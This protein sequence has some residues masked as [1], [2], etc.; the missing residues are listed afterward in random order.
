[1]IENERAVENIEEIL[2]VPRLGFA[3][4]GPADLEMSM[5]AGDPTNE[6]PEDVASAIDRTLEACLAA[7][8]P[9]G[10]IRN[11]TAD[12]QAAIDAGY[13]IVRIGGDVS[14]IHDTLGARLDELGP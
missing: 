1:M 5:S 10:R 14:S 2:A 13:R 3:F 6:S 11:D 7:D 8:I 12:A 4:V 9:I